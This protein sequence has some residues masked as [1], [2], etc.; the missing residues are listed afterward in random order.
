MIY[1]DR[2]FRPAWWAKGAHAQTILGR[3]MR[4]VK[5]LSLE[6]SRL[7][8]AD[9]DFIDIDFL[10][11]D[12]KKPF[13][14]VLH[15]LEGCS[16][17]PY[18]QSLLFTFRSRGWNAA[19]VNFRGCSVTLS[20]KR[21]LLAG[22]K[23]AH[24]N[25]LASTYHSGK[26]EDLDTVLDYLRRETG[27]APFF[28]AGFSIGGNILL[29][30]LGEQGEAAGRLIRKAAAVSVPYDLVKAVSVLDEGFNREVYTRSLLSTLKEKARSKAMQFPGSLDAV[31][32]KRCRTFA[33]FDREV[34]ARLNGFKDE[35]DYWTKSS[36]K[37]YLRDIRV[38]SLLL[39]A[40]DDPFYPGKFLPLEEIRGSTYLK[41][42]LTSEGGH[43]GFL[44]GPWPWAQEP[45]L[46]GKIMSYFED[47]LQFE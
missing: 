25:L 22:K 13:V 2:S 6:R 16:Y 35:M 26:S 7:E 14:V 32:L 47:T 42:L 30:W 8:T 10:R 20:E 38:P 40:G 24:P 41:L 31:K 45:W 11:G 17:A 15:G 21:F 12:A 34:T 3:F 23:T 4:T 19:A 5:P 39:H 28:A 1:P 27:A 33:E 18:I 37:H 43:V 44:A 9:N 46:E 36:S 29:K